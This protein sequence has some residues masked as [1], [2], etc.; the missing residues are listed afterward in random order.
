MSGVIYTAIFGDY[1]NLKEPTVVTK[2][3]DYRCYTNQNFDSDMW[4]IIKHSGYHYS[5]VK[6]SKMVKILWHLFFNEHDYVIWIDASL[7]INC[8][9]NRFVKK[10]YKPPFTLMTHPCRTCLYDEAR[11]VK[12]E[13]IDLPKIVDRQINDY[14][15]DGFPKDY[16]LTANGVMIW[17]R[18]S[19]QMYPEFFMFWWNQVAKYSHRDQLSFMYSAWKKEIKYHLIPYDIINNEFKFEKHKR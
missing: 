16:G 6:M 19:A 3:W 7:R 1:D 10:Y 12:K 13:K 17:D 15:D 11:I 2:G 5:N 4:T 8:D 18:E 9:L 14:R